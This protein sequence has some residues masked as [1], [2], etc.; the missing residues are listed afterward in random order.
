[1]KHFRYPVLI[2][3]GM[4]GTATAMAQEIPAQTMKAIYEGVK[5]PLKYGIVIRGEE[6]RPVDCPTVFRH[7]GA[8][9]MLYVCMNKVGYETHLAKSDDLLKWQTLGKVLTFRKEGWDRWQAD[10]GIALC[11]PTWGGSMELEKFEGK[12]WMSYIGG[13]LQGYETDPLA[14]GIATTDDPTAVKE[15]TRL[16][17]NPVLSRDQN[18]V[19]VWEKQ[20]LYKSQV[21]RDPNERVGFPFVMYYNGKIKSG[22]EKIGMAV[23]KDMVHWQR[24]G[25]DPVVSNGDEK[26]HGISGDPQIV[27]MGEHWVMFYFGAFWRPKAFDTFAVSKDLVHWTKWDGPHLI[28]TSEKWDEKYAHKPWVLKHDGVVYHFYC[29]VGSEGRVIALATSRPMGK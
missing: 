16:P 7:K 2:L 15:W 18:D 26:Q 6:G 11:D 4:A 29:A 21:I 23:S 13:A 24:F 10:G 20:T 19:R 5:T 12:Y 28:E 3:V 22:Y 17:D 8:W 14:I 25:V 1:M 9:W 27:R